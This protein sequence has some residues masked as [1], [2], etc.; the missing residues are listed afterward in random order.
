MVKKEQIAESYLIYPGSSSWSYY[1]YV[2]CTNCGSET[3]RIAYML[4]SPI[5]ELF[6]TP[7][8][9]FPDSPTMFTLETY[10]AN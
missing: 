5:A 7:P 10:C 1:D 8:T 6:A 4:E 9:N 2:D 3:R